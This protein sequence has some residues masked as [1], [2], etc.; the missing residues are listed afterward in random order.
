MTASSRGWTPLFLNALPQVIAVKWFPSTPE[1]MPAFS[2]S[3][4]GSWPSRYISMSSSSNSDTFS[5]ISARAAV[6]FSSRAAGISS[7]S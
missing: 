3:T 2:C 4:V 1:R 6:A 5:N 7:T